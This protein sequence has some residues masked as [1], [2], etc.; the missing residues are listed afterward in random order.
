V[1][2]SNR[3]AVVAFLLMV[4]GVGGNVVAVKLI[5]REAEMGPLWAGASRFF[6]ASILFA[7]IARARGAAMPRGRA[8]AGA[9][10]YG[11]L[12]I[13]GFFAFVYWG[14]QEA[15]AGMA[16]I[17]LAT[18]PLLTFVLAML[19]GQE[20]FRWDSMLGGAIAIAGTAVVF[21]V[22]VGAGVPVRSLLAILMGSLC[23]AEGAVIVKAFPPV[24]PSARN[25][26]GMSVG[27]F[28]L[29]VLVPV[30]GE[31]FT[32]PG[33]ATTWTAQIYLVT[34][35]SIGVFG[36]YLFLLERWSASVVSY[37]FVLA[38][39]VG[40][41]LAAWLLNESITTSFVL[42]SAL[43]LAGVYFGALRPARDA[44]AVNE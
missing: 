19:H 13:G 7:F 18:G 25:A 41:A 14:L 38:P 4:A 39:L 29:L 37:E 27:T 21:S 22:G 28:I 9:I 40:I 2:T 30:F 16:G 35:G 33:G 36:L 32:F 11:T 8:L 12:T 24:A 17:F 10:L 43:V 5:V 44:Q 20:R 31:S 15:P 1:K 6:L 34:G 23:A 42:G 3:I 26:I